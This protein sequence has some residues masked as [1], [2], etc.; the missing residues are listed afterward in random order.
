MRCVASIL[1]TVHAIRSAP[2]HG[3][4]TYV[5]VVAGLWLVLASFPLLFDAP[6]FVDTDFPFS[7]LLLALLGIV[8]LLWS[9]LRA[10]DAVGEHTGSGLRVAAYGI[11]MRLHLGAVLVVTGESPSVRIYDGLP[12]TAPLVSLVRHASLFAYGFGLGLAVFSTLADLRHRRLAPA[13][14]RDAT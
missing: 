2:T 4:T 5:A 11:A 13:W 8:T 6:S 3:T 12:E 7:L 1:R 9:G 10:F 14:V